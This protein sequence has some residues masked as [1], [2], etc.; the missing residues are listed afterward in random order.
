MLAHESKHLL[1]FIFKKICL[2]VDLTDD[3]LL[4]ANT[5][6]VYKC[7]DLSSE[8]REI[9][10]E[11]SELLYSLVSAGSQTIKYTEEM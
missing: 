9:Q 3:K 4:S 1:Y 8:L 7:T 11:I 5:H 6:I 10:T 2:N